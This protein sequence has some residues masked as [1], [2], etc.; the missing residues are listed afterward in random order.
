MDNP[1]RR[2]MTCPQWQYITGNLDANHEAR[3]HY[4]VE[5]GV[6]STG[7]RSEIV[8]DFADTGSR[9]VLDAGSARTYEDAV[10][11]CMEAY[12]R[13]PGVEEP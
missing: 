5:R 13:L 12:Y 8:G 10:D 1:I 3:V 9:V 6:Y 2:R 7:W 11:A 4:P